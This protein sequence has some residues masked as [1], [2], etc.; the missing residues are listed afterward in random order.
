MSDI[1]QPTE[2]QVKS[3]S[4]DSALQEATAELVLINIEVAGAYIYSQI[5]RYQMP[6]TTTW[7]A[8]NRMWAML[9]AAF[10]LTPMFPESEDAAEK[11]KYQEI[12]DKWLEGI[13]NPRI[14]LTDDGGA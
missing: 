12:V 10:I 1:N 9:A 14:T 5:T 7:T 2:A 3:I 4:P 8:L 6:L 11:S 13:N